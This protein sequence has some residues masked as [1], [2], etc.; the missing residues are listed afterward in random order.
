VDGR[1]GTLPWPLAHDNSENRRSIR[2]L[3]DRDPSFD[4][5]CMGHGDPLEQGGDRALAHLAR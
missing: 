4:I 3:A 2:A 5:A 1:L